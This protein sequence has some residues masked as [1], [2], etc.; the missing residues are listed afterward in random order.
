[1]LLIG[2]RA[3]VSTLAPIRS[4][5]QPSSRLATSSWAS[6]ERGLLLIQL[7][8]PLLWSTWSAAARTTCCSPVAAVSPY[9]GLTLP[10]PL[11]LVTALVLSLLGLRVRT[12]WWSS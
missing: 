9:L 4:Q 7:Q 5:R 8:S 11:A 6:P 2:L 10:V 12:L 3:S 1:M